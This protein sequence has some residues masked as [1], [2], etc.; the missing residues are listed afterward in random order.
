MKYIYL[1]Y[2]NLIINL[3]AAKFFIHFIN[4]QSN[5][6]KIINCFYWIKN[7]HHAIKWDKYQIENANF[8]KPKKQV[9]LE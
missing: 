6:F 3:N 7:Q 4:C 1:E 8:I 5:T 9:K 2:L